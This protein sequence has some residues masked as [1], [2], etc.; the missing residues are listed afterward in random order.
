MCIHVPVEDVITGRFSSPTVTT[1]TCSEGDTSTR[2]KN[3]V[4]QKQTYKKVLHCL[5][6]KYAVGAV[7]TR[8][9]KNAGDAPNNYTSSLP[10]SSNP[11]NTPVLST[12]NHVNNTPVL[13]MSR[14]TREF[15]KMI[16]AHYLSQFSLRSFRIAPSCGNAK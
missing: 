16:Y 13:S 11:V 2:V 3:Q 15:H 6:V 7:N 8:Q 12:L 4:W 14:D 1:R 10:G 9:L 5:P